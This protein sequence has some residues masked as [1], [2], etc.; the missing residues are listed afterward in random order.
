MNYQHIYNNL[1]VIA[2]MRPFPPRR[3][4]YGSVGEWHHI[5]PRS[6]GGCDDAS[7]LV[8]LFHREH[9]FAHR[10][11]ARIYRKNYGLQ[12]TVTYMARNNGGKHYAMD[13]KRASEASS[14]LQKGRVRTA[15]HTAK[16]MATRKANGTSAGW[17]NPDIRASRAST[18]KALASTPEWRAQKGAAMKA[19]HARRKAEGL[20]LNHKK[21]TEDAASE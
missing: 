12:T 13:R 14:N 1:V 3:K 8:F 19:Y 21:L 2:K 4:G 10:L 11:L 16:I 6:E 18:I 20:P 7:N 9:L 15:S 5:I 17:N